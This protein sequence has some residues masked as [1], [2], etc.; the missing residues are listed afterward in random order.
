MAITAKIINTSMNS[1]ERIKEETQLIQA[2]Y[3]LTL[4]DIRVYSYG[5]QDNLG[6]VLIFD[7]GV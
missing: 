3:Q 1:A 2:Q 5:N 4:S 6:V 7:D